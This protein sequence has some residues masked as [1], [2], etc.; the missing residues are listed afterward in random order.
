MNSRSIRAVVAVIFACVFVPGLAHASIIAQPSNNLGLVGYWSFDEGGGTS[1]PDHSGN[2]HVGT[3]YNSPAWVAGKYGG[4]LSLNGTNTYMLT[5]ALASSPNTETLSLW[6]YPQGGGVIVSELGQATINAGYHYE[7]LGIDTDGTLRGNIWSCNNTGLTAGI[8][9]MNTWYYVTL[10][11]TGTQEQLYLNG[12]LMNS[13]TCT[14]SPPTTQYL[15]FGATDSTNS[16]GFTD[17]GYFPGKIGDIRLYNRAL[18]QSEIQSLYTAGEATLHNLANRNG[19]VGEWS[20]DEGAG[21][22]ARDSS[23][24]GNTGTL[25]GSP[26]WVTG[27]H[28]GALSF[29]GSSSYVD[30]PASTSMNTSL[31]SVTG[32]IKPSSS[33]TGADVGFVSKWSANISDGW[34]VELGN[35]GDQARIYTQGTTNPSWIPAAYSFPVNQ[36]SFVGVVYDGTKKY[37]YVNG[38]LVDSIAATG[39]ISP[40]TKDVL[41]GLSQGS[42]ALSH[43]F[44][45]VIDD[46]KLYSRALS[47]NEI[48][49]LYQSGQT[50]VNTSSVNLQAGSTLGSGLVGLWTFD[51]KD[52]T[53]TT[54]YDRSN[55]GNNGTLQNSPTPTIGDLGQALLFNG[56]NQDVSLGNI[57][58]LNGAHAFTISLWIYK[59]IAGNFPA[60][61]GIFDIGSSANRM[62]FIWG[63]SGAS[64]LDMQFQTTTGGATDCNATTGA[65]PAN[66]WVHV[67]AWWDGSSCRFYVNGV[68]GGSDPTSGNTLVNNDGY[69][70]I[71]YIPSY[72]YWP[73]KIDDVRVYNRALSASEVM[74]L[75]QM[76][77]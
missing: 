28:G 1:A 9:S 77:Q 44:P 63:Y 37:F 75:Y 66:T 50:T 13:V 76:G 34:F 73:G 41:I 65:I 20:F 47:A 24:S 58:I 49:A 74:Q 16:G 57:A 29:N 18:S 2:G 11:Y 27:K 30:V 45:G 21:T 4:A 35:T 7:Q 62:P 10:E 48:Q 54:A 22:A 14:R 33:L 67:V 68:A 6:V 43:Y 31:F 64:Y 38:S 25:V 19:L 72:G 56:T 70:Y 8:L 60:H 17:T 59:N 71:G 55:S 5:N 40:T 36:W 12:T 46:V 52:L 69:G 51:G 32:W 42:G 3:L 61:D 15:A 39:N 53:S 26:A 23:G